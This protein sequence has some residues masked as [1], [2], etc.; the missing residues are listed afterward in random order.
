MVKYYAKRASE[1]EAIY[2]KPERQADLRQ[3]KRIVAEAMAGHEVLE[4]ACGTGY[5]TEAIAPSAR[6]VVA[7]D[8]NAEMI[9]VAREKRWDAGNVEFRLFDSYALPDFGREFT[10]AFAGFWWSHIPRARLGDF[11]RSLG[12][13]LAPGARVMFVDSRY[14]AGSNTPIARTDAAGDTFQMRRLADGSSHEVL[15]NFPD[16][17]ELR[18]IVTA[19]GGG[20][21]AVVTL[22][23]HFWVLTY[24]AIGGP[25]KGN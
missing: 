14:V 11:L 15:K 8:I 7:G 22:L 21:E 3:L 5:W 25:E 9:E 2:A 23:D 17:A 6:S 1:Y 13:K 16:E 10:A 12:S 18:R 24:R 4:L 20:R 19:S